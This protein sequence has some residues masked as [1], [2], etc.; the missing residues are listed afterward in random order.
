MPGNETGTEPVA[1]TILSPK[2]RVSLSFSSFIV[3]SFLDLKLPL[4]LK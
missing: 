2:I 1:I 3:I 4:P